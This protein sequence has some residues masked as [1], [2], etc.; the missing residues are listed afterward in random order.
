M[1]HGMTATLSTLSFFPWQE[2]LHA[3]NKYVAVQTTQMPSVITL[4]SGHRRV[5]GSRL[6][7]C[8]FFF[9]NPMAVCHHDNQDG[10]DVCFVIF[11][12]Y[13]QSG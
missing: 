4:I 8:L 1:V 13:F 5:A 11:T 2:E 3:G 7:G 12:L 10:S 9:N 6:V